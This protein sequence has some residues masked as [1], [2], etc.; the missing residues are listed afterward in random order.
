MPMT[1]GLDPVVAGGRYQVVGECV[2]VGC[3]G[4]IQ[5]GHGAGQDPTGIGGEGTGDESDPETGNWPGSEVSQL[6]SLVPS[7]E[8][9]I[10]SAVTGPTAVESDQAH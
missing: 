6:R 9:L 3:G 1:Y 10:P 2:G 4:D 5:A 7:E 8:R